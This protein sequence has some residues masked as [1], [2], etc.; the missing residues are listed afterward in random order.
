MQRVLLSSR[1]KVASFP[2]RKEHHINQRQNQFLHRPHFEFQGI[3][4]TL[5]NIYL[6]QHVGDGLGFHLRNS[7]DGLDLLQEGLLGL[8]ATLLPCAEIFEWH[9]DHE[10]KIEASSA[11]KAVHRDAVRDGLD[12]REDLFDSLGDLLQRFGS[13]LV[14]LVLAPPLTADPVEA[15]GTVGQVNVQGRGVAGEGGPGRGEGRG[16]G[17]EHREDGD[18]SLHG[19][20]TVEFKRHVQL[21]KCSHQECGQDFP[22]YI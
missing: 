6:D 4:L 15:H 9:S 19:C 11:N 13:R 3:A 5:F 1:E 12:L 14:P 17:S 10:L 7:I 2:L 18:G 22:K 21:K 16:R 20:W 8:V